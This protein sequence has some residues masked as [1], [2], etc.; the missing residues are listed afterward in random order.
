MARGYL[1]SLQISERVI[2]M[3][4]IHSAVERGE[5][6]K[7]REFVR[8]NP[9]CVNEVSKE[10]TIQPLHVAAWQNR[11][12]IAKFLI[13]KGA[14][15]NARGDGGRTPLHYA[16]Y[17]GNARCVTLLI[18]NKADVDAKR[19]D[20]FTP[21]FVAVRNGHPRIAKCLIESGAEYDLNLAVCM[22]DSNRVKEV[23]SESTDPIGTARFSNDLVLDAVIQ[24]STVLKYNY[25]D[26][27]E[28]L[29]DVRASDGILR[30][31]LENGAPVG[32][33]DFGWDPLFTSCQ[34]EHPYITELLL[35]NGADPNVMHHGSNLSLVP[36]HSMCEKEMLKIL[37]KYGFKG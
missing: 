30:I 5:L 18:S 22:G 14:N 2:A 6:A 4:T 8:K 12:K 13:E 36:K 35:K 7:V 32:P 21:A 26:P 31:L 9:K 20:N 1:R 34:M 11:I 17:H 28:C 33:P 23:V 25:K 19:D 15:V 27:Q 29:A 10:L 37:R 3:G 16:A 24:I